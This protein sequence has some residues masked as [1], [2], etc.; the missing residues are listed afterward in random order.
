MTND[1]FAAAVERLWPG[2]GG[3]QKATV[4][5]G[6]KDSRTIRKYM[7]GERPVAGWLDSEITDLLARFPGGVTEVKPRGTIDILHSHMVAAGFTRTEAA[8]GVLG[9]AHALALRELGADGVR[10]LLI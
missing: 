8:A 6:W 4:Y 10:G 9:A 7:T 5:F 3:R 2:H 1:E